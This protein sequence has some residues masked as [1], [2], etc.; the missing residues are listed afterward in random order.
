MKFSEPNFSAELF[1]HSRYFT[2]RKTTVAHLPSTYAAI[3]G[4]LLQAYHFTNISLKILDITK[5]TLQPLK[6]S[7]HKI[8]KE[9]IIKCACKK[10]CDCCTCEK[11]KYIYA[12]NIENIR[13]VKIFNFF[14][15]I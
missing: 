5:S 10:S 2:N 6:F 12:Q 9:F 7:F 3:Q 13:I 8:P 14:S 4:H 1:S 15:F 11:H